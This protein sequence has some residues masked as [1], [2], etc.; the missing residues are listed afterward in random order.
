[1]RL[2]VPRDGIV[3][4]HSSLRAVGWIVGGPVTVVEAL[5]DVLGPDGTI[6]VPTHTGHN[7]DPSRWVRPWIA[8]E[9]WDR[10]RDAIPAF[11][12]QLTP[13]F[14]LGQLAEC[15]RTWPGA[16]RSDHP[17]T[18]FAAIGPAAAELLAGHE[19]TSP[20]GEQSPLRRLEEANGY[21]LLLGTGYDTCTSFHLAEYRA[22]NPPMQENACAVRTQRGREWVRYS[23]VALDDGD[24]DR[25]GEHFEQESNRVRVGPVGHATARLLP[26]AAAVAFASAWLPSFQRGAGGNRWPVGRP[27]AVRR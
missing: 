25:L 11:D 27:S 5:R 6:G 9:L 17:Q 8:E 1:M 10:V 26:V 18:S 14:G 13:S 15:V 19:L 23:T 7:R 21:A 2:G 4:V 3:L 16:R 24:F 12:P 20:L 22:S